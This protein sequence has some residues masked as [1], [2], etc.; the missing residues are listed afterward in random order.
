MSKEIAVV[1]TSYSPLISVE[2]PYNF[3][4]CFLL[5]FLPE[6]LF[7]PKSKIPIVKKD[8]REIAKPPFILFSLKKLISKN[9]LETTSE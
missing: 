9:I 7:L 1:E 6:I 4:S 8:K 5:K 3:F 2:K